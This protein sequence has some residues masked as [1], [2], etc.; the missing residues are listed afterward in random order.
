MFL[1]F[2]PLPLPALLFFIINFEFASSLT[3]STSHSMEII[4]V[5]EP[6]GCSVS[7]DAVKENDHV[8][9]EVSISSLEQ[10]SLYR[11]SVEK[12]V[13]GGKGTIQA[14]N[15]GLPGMCVGSRRKL[16]AP[17]ALAYG[18][19]GAGTL[20]PLI[21]IDTFVAIDDPNAANLQAERRRMLQEKDIIVEIGVLSVTTKEEYT[22]FDC[23]ASNTLDKQAMETCALRRFQD[24]SDVTVVDDHGNTILMNAVQLD[25]KTLF[26]QVLNGKSSKMT[27]SDYVNL[28]KSSG[29]SA[30]FYAVQN[31]DTFYVKALLKRGADP[32]VSLKETGWT[33]IHFAGKIGEIE[34]VKFMLNYGGN[35][36]ATTTE[37]L[38]IL[39]AAGERP[40]SFRSKLIQYL[41]EALDAIYD[42]EDRLE[43]GAGER[44]TGEL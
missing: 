23:F 3:V 26:S 19:S 22:I 17:P 6:V 5:Y 16:I 1:R 15:A 13:I 40:Y 44:S 29:H 42:E 8:T 35:P 34:H 14:I 39:D 11:S 41:N 37:G 38:S 12:F 9:V 18:V 21:G 27:M 28:Q 2:L 43:D 24:L 36:M 10:E 25:M 7:D 20:R 33:P 4:E 30:L 32:N 31:E